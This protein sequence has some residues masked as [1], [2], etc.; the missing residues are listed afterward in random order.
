M[1]Q[2]SWQP[3][4]GS[5]GNAGWKQLGK[6]KHKSTGSHIKERMKKQNLTTEVA[7]SSAPSKRVGKVDVLVGAED[8]QRQTVK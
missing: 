2:M 8:E 4:S 1:E 5:R 7:E 6:Q 3:S